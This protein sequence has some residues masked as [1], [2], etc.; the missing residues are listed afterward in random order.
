MG[1]KDVYTDKRFIKDLY[2]LMYD[3]HN[4]FVENDIF[5]YVDGGTL[6]GAV[7]HKGIIPWDDDVDLEVGYDDLKKVTSA[8]VRKQFDG[9]GYRVKKHG[10]GWV[11]IV[12]KGRGKQPDADVFPVMVKKEGGRYRTTWDFEVGRDAWPKCYFYMDELL[13]LKMYKFGKVF[14]LGPKN[15]RPMLNRCYGP[16]WSKKGYITQDKHHMPLDEPI[17]VKQGDFHAGKDFYVPTKPQIKPSKA[18]LSGE[19]SEVFSKFGGRKSPRKASRR[20]RSPQRRSKSPKK[21][22]TRRR[23]PRKK[24]RRR[25]K[26]PKKCPRGKVLSPKGRCI[27]RGGAA[28]RQ[29]FG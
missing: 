13:P 22:S 23:S 21:R 28:Y 18:Y 19:T 12:K 4:V 16:S 20:R 25:S 10:E 17:L 29:Y 7:R 1:E 11:K 6:M 27:I 8:P 24:S 3:L 14:C 15:P 26:S 5:Y 2:K 9:L